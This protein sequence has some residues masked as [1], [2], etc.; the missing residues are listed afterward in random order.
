MTWKQFIR[1][2]NE[3]TANTSYNPYGVTDLDAWREQQKKITEQHL[4][5]ERETTFAGGCQEFSR[6]EAL[7]KCTGDGYAKGFNKYKILEKNASNFIF[8]K[9]DVLSGYVI[10]LC[11]SNE[12]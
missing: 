11:H 8:S 5:E 3:M 6:M 9:I 10:Y 7:V 12:V 1:R 2:F 4:Q